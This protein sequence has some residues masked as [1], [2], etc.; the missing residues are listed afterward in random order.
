MCVTCY[1][2]YPI[3]TQIESKVL[4]DY[5]WK[6]GYWVPLWGFGRDVDCVPWMSIDCVRVCPFLASESGKEGKKTEKFVLIE[7]R[8]KM[9]CLDSNRLFL[10]FF[11]LALE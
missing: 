9:C 2:R 5:G 6:V 10:S 8:D 7:K 11:L 4:S 3:P 1:Y